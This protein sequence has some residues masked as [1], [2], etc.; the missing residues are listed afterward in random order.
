MEKKEVT[1]PTPVVQKVEQPLPASSSLSVSIKEVS[2]KVVVMQKWGAPRVV[3]ANDTL[4]LPIVIQTES[5][6]EAT[7]LFTDASL[8]RLGSNTTLTL[9]EGK[10]GNIVAVMNAGRLWARI[11]GYAGGKLPLSISTG[12]TKSVVRGTAFELEKLPLFTKYTV[13]DSGATGSEIPGLDILHSGSLYHI[14]PE[15]S[16]LSDI[17]NSVS[18][19]SINI[20]ELFQ[21]DIFALTNTQKDILHMQG[22]LGSTGSGVI[23]MEKIMREITAS[24]P[25]LGSNEFFAFTSGSVLSGLNLGTGSGNDW[26][27]VVNAALAAQSANYNAYMNQYEAYATRVIADQQ[28]LLEGI[29]KDQAAFLAANEANIKKL[30]AEQEMMMQDIMTETSKYLGQ[31]QTDM[32]QLFAEQETML[33]TILSD[34]LSNINMGMS[35]VNIDM[36]KIMQDAMSEASWSMEEVDMQGIVTN[37]M[38]EVNTSSSDID[39]EDD[40]NTEDEPGE[41]ADVDVDNM[42]LDTDSQDE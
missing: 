30:L 10:W 39:T 27:K 20:G 14:L 26:E 3:S 2:G 41:E 1:T 37:A 42:D 32:N 5:W 29:M 38:N 28:K 24:L 36:N 17:T 40:N 8:L 7:I 18:T 19:G 31:V 4:S 23:D 13:L 22:I 21:K 33:N 11:L 16:F 6:S 12:D 15:Q 9:T 25:K 35:G 34:T